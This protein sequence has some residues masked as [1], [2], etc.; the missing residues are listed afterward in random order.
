MTAI[1]S[2][3]EMKRE[4]WRRGELSWKLDS[5]QRSVRS[6]IGNTKS[7][8]FCI[9]SSRQ[10]GKS[11]LATVLALEHCLHH[12]GSIVRIL[13][14]T[15]KQVGDIVQ[16]NLAPIA[17]DSPHGLI[18]R[19]K[20]DYRW[21]VGKSSL[22]LASLER[23]HVDNARGGNASLVI[24]EEGGFVSSDDY[25][26]AVE[27]V[28]GPQLLR[29]GG[30]EIHIS[31]PSKDEYHY[32]HET[33][34]ERC[35]LSDSLYVYTVYDS[36]SI[37]EEQIHK[38]AERCG[39]FHTDAWKC[40]YLAQIIRSKTYAVIP[41]FDEA[42]HVGDFNLPEFYNPFVSMDM[43][44]SKDKTH[45]SLGVW[46]FERARLLIWDEAL[47]DANTA[48]KSIVDTS[49]GLEG[50][51]RWPDDSDGNE[52]PIRWADVPGQI[53]VDLTHQFKF[54][55]RIPPKDD[56]Q[57]QINSLRLGFSQ[58]KVLIHP[59]CKALIGCLKTARY[60]N[61]RTDFERTE[62][63]GHC[64][65]LMSLVYGYRTADRLTNPVPK[66]AYYRDSQLRVESRRE[67]EPLEN[68]ALSL[69][70][71]NPRRR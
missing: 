45:I 43:G 38:A 58:G 54:Y 61:K 60:N 23:S 28:I 50:Q 71:Y 55:V 52:S 7:D 40:E 22:R 67:R 37:T 25:R 31:S 21:T 69:V 29:S 63:Y 65:P 49:Y 30:A 51:L 70:P 16:D 68:V 19:H 32:L 9:L 56:L 24:F 64:D 1:T 17:L 6:H 14:A 11:Y 4:L 46:D 18:E 20:S 12:P 62:A 34:A 57:A 53:Q 2:Y 47:F 59:R 15:L 48:T 27:S 13:A 41:E 42:L 3:D 5:L 33:V 66:A 10:I 44:G 26:Y 35:R 8:R 36:P 39:G